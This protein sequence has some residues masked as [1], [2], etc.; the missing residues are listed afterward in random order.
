MTVNGSEHMDDRPAEMRG[1]EFEPR[2][3]TGAGLKPATFG[4]ARPPSRLR[5]S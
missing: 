4:Q 1:K 5:S 2:I 3:P